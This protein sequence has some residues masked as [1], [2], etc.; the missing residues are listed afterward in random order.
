MPPGPYIRDAVI[1]MDRIEV[2]METVSMLLLLLYQELYV[3]KTLSLL[4]SYAKSVAI[5]CFSRKFLG[6]S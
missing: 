3:S 6:L 2:A 1:E 5:T 4:F